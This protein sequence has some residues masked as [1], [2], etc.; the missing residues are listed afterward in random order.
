MKGVE[1][2]QSISGV[3]MVEPHPSMPKVRVTFA[4]KTE[5]EKPVAYVLE[6]ED[7]PEPI[8]KG[9]FMVSLSGNGKKMFSI[10]P[11]T[12]MAKLKVKE[13]PAQRDAQGNAKEPAPKTKTGK[14]GVYQTFSVVFEIV[15]GE[16]K[17]M[18][19][20]GSFPFDFIE[21]QDEVDGKIVSVLNV[22][23]KKDSPGNDRLWELLEVTGVVKKTM[24]YK[25]NPLPMLQKYMLKEDRTFSGAY[26][27]G[28]INSLFSED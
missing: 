11:I 22:K 17:G 16:N 18:E 13:F 23:K 28:W 21:G 25:E 8:R 19:M 14:F 1:T 15:E 5:G 10:R 26:K 3:A 12:G 2:G 9:K 27:D 4:P 24:P 6:K 7:C 20:P